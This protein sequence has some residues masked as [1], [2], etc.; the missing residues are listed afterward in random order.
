MFFDA[1]RLRR[2][3]AA[4]SLC[5]VNRRRVKSNMVKTKLTEARESRPRR[6]ASRHPPNGYRAIGISNAHLCV[7]SRLFASPTIQ[8]RHWKPIVVENDDSRFRGTVAVIERNDVLRCQQG[9]A[10]R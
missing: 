5:F 7:E 8:A 2:W 3:T 1:D 9:A 10:E 6:R 4:V